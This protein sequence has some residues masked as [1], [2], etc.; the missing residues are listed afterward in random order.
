MLDFIKNMPQIIKETNTPIKLAALFLI[1]AS[2]VTVSY[3]SDSKECRF[4]IVSPFEGERVSISLTVKGKSSHCGSSSTIYTVALLDKDGD[5]YSQGNILVSND[6]AWSS[7]LYLSDA[8]SAKKL[9][10]KVVGY[11]KSQQWIDGTRNLPNGSE[12]FE[13]VNLRV[14]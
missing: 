5:Y 2:I 1:L 13:E 3:M 12:V 6:G 9:I 7:V 14:N 8:W 11:P 10:L 4:S